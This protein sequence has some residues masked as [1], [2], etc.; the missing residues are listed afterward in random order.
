MKF[1]EVV[2]PP[3]IYH[4]FSTQKTFW[5]EKFTGKKDLFQSMN[6]KNGGCRKVRKH[7]DIK[8]SDKIVT[9]NVSEKFD[10]L[11]KMETTSSESKEKWGRS[12]KGLVTALY[13]KTKVRPQKYKKAR[14]AIGNV[15][16]KDLSNI[17]KEFE[18]IVKVSYVKRI[19]RHEPISS[20]YHLVRCI[21]ECMMES[22]EHNRR[23]HS[24][25]AEE[26]ATSSN[27]NVTDEDE[28]KEFILHK[29]VSENLSMDVS[30][31][32]CNIVNETLLQ[33]NLSDVPTNVIT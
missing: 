17:I 3:S 14:Y 1:L 23:V 22:D 7:K 15:S 30:E 5:E 16:M 27:V 2:T 20:Y 25:Y 9:L 32:E 21:A 24:S 29:P 31:S 8:C 18:K 33:N 10:S 13:L 28:S 26:T 6:M 11:S 12:G 19:P 4:G